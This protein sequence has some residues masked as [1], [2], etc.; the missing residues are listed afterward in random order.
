MVVPS[1]DR[2]GCG[3]FGPGQGG[4]MRGAMLSVRR[5]V[6]RALR[7][8]RPVRLQLGC[9]DHAIS[10]WI[11]TDVTTHLH[12]AQIPGLAP[13]LHQIGL[14]SSQRAEQHRAGVFDD[15]HYLD[16]GKPFPVADDTVEAIF[17][18]HV[19]EHLTPKV[20]K[21]CVRES[22]R[23][24][25]PGGVL[26][27]GVPDLDRLVANYDSTDPDSFVH[28]MF[29]AAQKRDKNRHFWMYNERSLRRL[30]HNGGFSDVVRRP[31]REGRC[32][33]LER[34]DNRPQKTLFM[35]ATK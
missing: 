34:L 14:L 10:G 30:L 19:L 28:E 11:N 2:P 5:A 32:P 20:A 13:A 16:V 21:H 23:V 17:H 18:A 27:V 3:L 6:R 12:I 31:Y 29:E 9:F 4:T 24:L 35:E 33:D 8:G 15:V 25:A 7:E 26:R 1:H 22:Y